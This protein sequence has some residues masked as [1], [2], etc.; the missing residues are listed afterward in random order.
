[1]LGPM[2]VTVLLS[3]LLFFEG[4]NCANLLWTYISRGS[5]LFDLLECFISFP[6]A[7]KAGSSGYLLL[8]NYNKS[9]IFSVKLSHEITIMNKIRPIMETLEKCELWTLLK[10]LYSWIGPGKHDWHTEKGKKKISGLMRTS[11]L[12]IIIYVPQFF[13]IKIES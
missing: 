3:V 10:K 2:T 12:I 4:F 1:M 7:R 11:P 6:D 8:Y 5:I 9:S 13:W